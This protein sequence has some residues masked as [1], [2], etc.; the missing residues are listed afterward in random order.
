MPISKFCTSIWN[1]HRQH[2]CHDR[3][4]SGKMQL[5]FDHFYHFDNK[6]TILIAICLQIQK[7]AIIFATYQ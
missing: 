6:I 7:N 4:D 2:L 3:S 5:K 1:L